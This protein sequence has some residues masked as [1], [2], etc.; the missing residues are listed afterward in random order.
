MIIYIV[1]VH[2]QALIFGIIN[3]CMYSHAQFCIDS[4]KCM[5]LAVSQIL[6]FPFTLLCMAAYI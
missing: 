6:C 1:G 5:D 2:C 4:I 3:G